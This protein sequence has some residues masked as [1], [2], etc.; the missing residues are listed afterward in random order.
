[1]HNIHLYIIRTRKYR[2]TQN[3]SSLEAEVN[4]KAISD[5]LLKKLKEIEQLLYNVKELPFYSNFL[6]L[7][8]LFTMSICF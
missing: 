2:R 5:T 6:F 4:P 7:Q 3:V 8:K 1:M